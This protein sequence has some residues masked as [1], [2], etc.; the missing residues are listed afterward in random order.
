MKARILVVDDDPNFL[1]VISLRL[2]K[3][4]YDVIGLADEHKAIKAVSEQDIE[5]A[6]VDLQLK[7]NDGISLMTQLH[8]IK[9]DL[10]IIILTAYGSIETAVKAME[11]GAF[12]YLTKPFKKREL[13][14]HLERALE[15]RF[16]HQEVKRLQNLVKEYSFSNIVAKSSKMCQVLKLVAQIAP[17]DSTVVI[18]GESGTGK[19]LIAKAIHLASHRAEGPFVALNCAALP[20]SLLESELFGHEKGAFTGAV[21]AN[22]GLFVA[23]NKGT[24]FLDE[25]ADMPLSIQ[26][27]LLR[28]IQEKQFFPL[29]S[30]TPVKVDVRIIA[31]TNKD[32]REEVEAGTFRRDLFYRIHVIPIHLPPLRERKED[33]PYLVEHFVKKHAPRLGKSIKRVEET[34]IKKLLSYDWPGN[35]REL[36]NIIEYALVLTEGSVLKA[37]YIMLPEQ[38]S[39]NIKSFKEAKAEFERKYLCEVL[40]LTQGNISQAATLAGKY[41]ADFYKLLRKH[42]ID[43]QAFKLKISSEPD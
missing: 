13:L 42:Q 24:I 1:H 2:K 30:D 20:E 5:V 9:P 19:E 12:T 14:A 26:A 41:R 18:Q 6:I 25:I 36:E 10:P 40:R 32:L 29:G 17:T 7:R 15:N 11:K 34:A 39:S 38:S 8:L 31:A 28:V 4:G 22:K 43:P 3:A 23:A 37:D 35:I 27:K 33:I 21:T 16:L